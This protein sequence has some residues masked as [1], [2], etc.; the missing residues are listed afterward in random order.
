MKSN[1][2]MW[3]SLLVSLCGTALEA[4]EAPY[5]PL[6][7]PAVEVTARPDQ[8]Q[9]A[10]LWYPG[11]LS[12]HLQQKRIRESGERCV[13]V[14]YPGKFYA[15]VGRAFFRKQF[16]LTN[17]AKI[18]WTSTGTGKV[19]VNNKPS[20]GRHEINLPQGTSTLVFEVESTDNLPSLRAS[21]NG[22][23]TTEGWQASLDGEGWNL[24]ETSPVFGAGGRQPL[25]D[26][27]IE[28]VIPPA[29]ITSVAN[30]TIKDDHITLE[31]NGSVLIDFFHLEVG[32]VFFKAKGKGN[33]SVVVGESPEEA[34]N[35]DA[36]SFEQRPIAA[37]PL[38]ADE[39]E[40]V[41][42]ERAVRYVRITSD[43]GCDVS[44]VKFT[45]KV[46]PVQFHMSF[47]CNDE[48]MNRIWNVS[49]A[50][51]HAGMHGFYLDGLKRDYLP[52][53]M[54]AVLSTFGGDYVFADRQVSRN[55]LSVALLPLNPR[56]SD[57]GIPDYP[58][59]ALI[60]FDHYHKRYGD[61]NAILAYRDRMEQLL[62]FYETLQDERG[63]ITA[64]VGGDFGFVPGWGTL[65]GPDNKGTPTYA[66]IMLYSNYVIG[67]RFCEQWGDSA[68]A[69]HYRARAEELKA[70]IFKHLWNE[71]Q[72]LFIN[73]FTRDGQRDER[74]SHHAQYWAI[75]AGI[76]PEERYDNL[77]RTLPAI[78]YYRDFVSFE[79]GYEFMA[80]AKARRVHEMWDFL[81]TVFDDWL[82]QGHTRFPENF[83]FRKPRNE[84]LVFYAR[85]YGLSLCHG[86][87]GVPGIIAVLQGIAGFRQSDTHPNHYTLQPDL[88]HLEWAHIEFP[89]K[90]GAIKLKLQKNAPSQ[91]EIPPGCRV[92]YIDQN[93]EKRTLK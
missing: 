1:I 52:W 10:Y 37:F 77:F 12:A 49:V 66:Q 54:D 79:K 33:V 16:D 56:Q 81:F 36:K 67:A 20:G 23:P 72:G 29:V 76:F 42:P 65:L 24:A 55:S 41:L 50:T 87:N 2:H 15:P 28:A 59:H 30:A 51:L 14:G 63:F 3:C 85:P 8:E 68:A 25:D 64:A 73:G 57:L 83:S 9:G 60:G 88:L 78:P 93:G 70:A 45:A 11:Q 48:R 39:Q 58:L 80:Y 22:E 21:L 62:A 38:S 47:E 53:S 31:P 13:Y 75:L 17:P 46:W 32:R 86:A 40:I 27:E 89:V 44:S 69:K 18:E 90:E 7:D 26:P 5:D 34:L 71:E 91:I 84:Q 43:G 19:M 92:D 74:I 61:F 82:E 4:R 35:D 6:C